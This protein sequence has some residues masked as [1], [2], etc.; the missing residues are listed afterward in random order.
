MNDQIDQFGRDNNKP[1]TADIDKDKSKKI[2]ESLSEIKNQLED[3]NY[4]PKLESSISKSN[5][6]TI[7]NKKNSDFDQLHNKIEELEIK[8][9]NL[10]NLIQSSN[11]NI[12]T[13]IESSLDLEESIFHNFNNKDKG[14][15]LLVLDEKYQSKFY[16][17]KF[18]H[19]LI[20]TI[21]LI[22]ILILLS[23]L[24]LKINFPEVI[25]IFLSKFN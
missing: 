5:K 14:K 4:S 2:L 13:S 16:K 3:K 19:F 12:N 25:N 22:I 10:S 21:F 8:I 24:Q 11:N 17:F 15:S 9:S 18:Y 7:M 23:S 6:D 20:L 1:L